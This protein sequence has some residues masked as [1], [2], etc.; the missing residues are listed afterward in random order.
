MNINDVYVLLKLYLYFMALQKISFIINIVIQQFFC[1]KIK[2]IKKFLQMSI[3]KISLYDKQT[4]NLFL[5]FFK[6]HKF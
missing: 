2:I 5:T 4:F 3:H 1:T 6:F